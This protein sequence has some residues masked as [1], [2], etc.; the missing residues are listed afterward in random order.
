MINTYPSSELRNTFLMYGKTTSPITGT[1]FWVIGAHL[2]VA[3]AIA[4]FFVFF[5]QRLG[6]D[7]WVITTSSSF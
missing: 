1:I 2:P 4:L 3:V 7:A 6:Y 5:L